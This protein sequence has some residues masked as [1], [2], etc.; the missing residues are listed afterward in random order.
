VLGRAKQRSYGQLT[1]AELV[2]STAH[3][4]AAAR[5]AGAGLA[6][7][8][9][10]RFGSGAARLRSGWASAFAPLL[11]AART[12]ARHAT[13]AAAKKRNSK[14]DSMSR[15]WPLVMGALAT[16]AA[17]GAGAYAARKRRTAG[18]NND[19][20]D[21][22][23]QDAPQMDAIEQDAPQ[24]EATEGAMEHGKDLST[25]KDTFSGAAR[26]VSETAASMS[27]TAKSRSEKAKTAGPGDRGP[28]KPPEQSVEQVTALRSAV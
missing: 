14:G 2:E 11:D 24:T 15:K 10:A 16:T 4:R 12:E 17:V 26:T 5:H 23:E 7:T 13:K 6:G 27:E 19:V 28:I 9:G 22:I 25:G 1:R 18:R 21:A 3:L 8:G 20:P